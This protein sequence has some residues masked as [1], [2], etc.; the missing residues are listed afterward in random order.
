[1]HPGYIAV[2]QLKPTRSRDLCQVGAKERGYDEVN[3]NVGCPSDRVQNGR[4][5]A[6]LMAETTIGGRLRCS[7]ERG[8]GYSG[9][10][11]NPYWYRRSRLLSVSHRFCVNSGRKRRL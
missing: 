3:L 9:D 11:Q 10:G 2:G 6:C 8:G 7:D 5:G 4:F 1:M